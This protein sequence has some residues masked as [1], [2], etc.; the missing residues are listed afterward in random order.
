MENAL[1][2][3]G[4]RARTECDDRDALGRARGVLTKVV[5][6]VGG[7]RFDG[8]ILDGRRIGVSRF[9]E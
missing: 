1:I 2:G 5:A 3:K 6:A 9:V 4:M 7:T 8:P